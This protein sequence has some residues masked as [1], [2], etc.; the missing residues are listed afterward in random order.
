MIL[1]EPLV[2]AADRHRSGKAMIVLNMFK[3]VVASRG[4]DPTFYIRTAIVAH[5]CVFG[6]LSYRHS[7]PSVKNRDCSYLYGFPTGY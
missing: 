6:R 4:A 3:T 7:W 2:I 5:S 1:D